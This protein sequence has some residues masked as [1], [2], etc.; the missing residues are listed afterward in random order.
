MTDKD[1]E[2]TDIK[3]GR[4]FCRIDYRCIHLNL[5]L[6]TN[7]ENELRWVAVVI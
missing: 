5:N 7:A 2:D 6:E 3:R 4:N 1:T